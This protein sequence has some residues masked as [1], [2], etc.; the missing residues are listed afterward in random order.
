MEL[1]FQIHILTAFVSCIKVYGQVVQPYKHP[2]LQVLA[3]ASH[4]W[5]LDAVEGI[6]D[7]WDLIGNRPGH[8]N[9]SNITLRIHN[10]TVLPSSHNSSYVYTNDSAYT[11][12]SATVDIV[13][14]MVNKG[15]FLNGDNGGTFLHFGSYQNSCISDPTLCGPEGIT[16]SFFWKNQEAQSRFAFASGGKVISNGFSVY[17]NPHG[18]YVEFYTRGNHQR[19]KTNISLPGPFWTHVLFTWTLSDGLKV[20]IN[21]T[22]CTAD[23]TGSVSKNYGDPYPDLVIGTGNDKA[24]GHYVTGAFDEFVIWERALLPQ[25]ILLYYNAAI[26]QAMVSPT[27]P[28]V[29][30]EVIITTPTLGATE[31]SP[32][33]ISSEPDELH[34]SPDPVESMPILGFLEALPRNLPNRTIPYNTANNFTQTFLK[35][36]EEVLS[37]PG[38]IVAKQYSTPVVSGLIETV[39]R[40]ME[41]MVTNLEPRPTSLISLD[42]TSFVADYSLM[43]FPQNYNLPHY[44]F[45]TQG[46]N[47]ISVPGEAFTMESQTTIVGLFYHN[48]HSYYKEISPVKTRIN[49]AANFRDHKI[50][51]AS[52]LIS[53]KVEPSPAL[54]VNLSGAPLIKIVLTHV[55]SK[56]QQDQALNESNKVFLY[57]AFLDYSSKE[58][59]WSNEGCV[60]SSGNMTYSVCLCNHLTNFAILMQVVPIKLT[61]VHR[62]ALSTIG[63]VGC[64]VSIFCLAIT[65][66][67]FA[68]LSSV[69]TIRNQRYHIH[70][71]LSFAILVAEILLLISSRFDPG[72]LPCK[73]MAILLH[74]FFLSAF[75][76]MLVEGLHLYSM[77]VKVF[78]SED[79]KHFYYYGIGWG[80]PLVICVVS[81]TSALDSYGESDNCWL[82]LKNGAIWAFVAPALL[83]IVVNIGILVSVTRIISRISAENYKVHGDANAVKLTAKAVAVLLPILGISWIFGVLAVNTHSL[84]F[85]YIFAVFNSLQG[86]FVFLFHCL[87]NSEVRAAFKHK[88]KVWS[89][90]SSSI[91]NINVKPFNSDIMN[92]NKEGVTP[93]KMNTWDKS[94]NSA[95]RI[96][97]SAV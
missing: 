49:K 56:N 54:S 91:R 37:S 7:L 22:F 82:S 16:F 11:N 6:H 24:Y 53:L 60:R 81:I 96:D 67:T 13:E 71:N 38:W 9:G 4:Y 44:R 3:T 28:S 66:V 74:F 23:P 73:V 55:L 84:P 50:Q 72:T 62:V 85:L 46:K 69:S 41:H 29:P 45:P 12:I 58:G 39:D 8:I 21:G 78:G 77:V 5:P 25:D 51:V 19:W 90:T 57:C 35:S 36:V 20:F 92:G 40:V 80:S 48:M 26:G 65:L 32:P 10:H 97:L 94:T 70:A 93:T 86:F 43:K 14:G 34:S 79:S 87:L 2:G 88:T 64:S 75:A 83:V 47:Y 76:W 89:L 61:N 1:S 68:I 52:C 31:V 15:I 27:T 17:A 63:Y 42:G 30:Q 18:G 95:N 59:V 33:V